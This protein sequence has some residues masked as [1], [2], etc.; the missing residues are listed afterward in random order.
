[1]D[2]DY[3]MVTGKNK[4]TGKSKT[5]RIW[6]VA[7]IAGGILLVAL[8]YFA[9]RDKNQPTPPRVLGGAK[10]DFQP[11]VTG[12]PAISV[13]PQQIDL[14]E[15]KLGTPVQASFIVTNIGDKA[16][17]FIEAPYIELIEGC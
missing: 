14:G 4:K 6:P 3:L 1:L 7:L 15:V 17:K 11:Q 9:L 10:S 12:A 13:E 5:S 8:A 2:E 16:L